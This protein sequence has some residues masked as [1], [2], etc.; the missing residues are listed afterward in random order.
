ME[1]YCTKEG[2]CCGGKV[3]MVFYIINCYVYV[4]VDKNGKIIY[5]GV[6]YC[7]NESNCIG[8][9]AWMKC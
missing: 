5:V 8:G 1:N 9:K 2:N 6:V 7:M 3:W 4:Y